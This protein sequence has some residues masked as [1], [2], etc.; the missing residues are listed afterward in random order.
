[1]SQFEPQGTGWQPSLPDFRDFTPESPPVQQLLQQLF[2]AGATVPPTEPR[3]DLTEYF[4]DPWDQLGLQSSSAHACLGLLEY[5]ERRAHGRAVRPSRMFLYYNARRLAG[6]TGDSGGDLR[7]ALKA[8]ARCGVPPEH[9]WPYD[10]GRLDVMPEPYLYHHGAGYRGM[11]YL[12]VDRRNQ[13]GSVTLTRIK[14]FLAAGFPLAFGVALPGGLSRNGVLPYRPTFEVVR[15][16]QAL[17]AV[18][19]DDVWLDGSRGALRVRNSWGTG[20][21]ENGYGWLPYAYV[22]EQ[23]ALEFWT[24][25]SREWLSA[26]DFGI[27][28]LSL[29][30]N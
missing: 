15:G 17:V 21:G 13:P 8:L 14:A 27:P 18:G 28:E 10:P 3:V 22:E 30:R 23:L 4:V 12:R 1:M 11:H 9:Q 7:S 5:F 24:L 16:G 20:W 26:G 19:Y 2:D 29:W 25:I 6:S